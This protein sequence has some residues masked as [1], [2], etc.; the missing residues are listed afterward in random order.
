[1][2]I[3][4]QDSTES[5][6]S[7]SS[8]QLAPF[9]SISESFSVDKDDVLPSPQPKIEEAPKPP[10]VD[11]N[12]NDP[13]NP[14]KMFSKRLHD[15]SNMVKYGLIAASINSWHAMVAGASGSH[16]SNNIN[17]YKQSPTIALAQY[18]KITIKHLMGS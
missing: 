10:T 12:A 14:G 15:F 6:I 9:T 2:M 16:Y 1:M 11:K 17:S 3:C 7:T 8:N 13:K 4:W 18:C 5:D